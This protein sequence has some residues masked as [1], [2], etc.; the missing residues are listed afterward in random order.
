MLST[1][2]C[3]I[4][5]PTRLAFLD[6]SPPYLHFFHPISKFTCTF[7]PNSITTKFSNLIVYLGLLVYEICL[8]YPPYLFIW[9]YLFNW[10][11]RVHIS[12]LLQSHCKADDAFISTNSVNEALISQQSITR[13]FNR[14]RLLQQVTIVKREI[15]QLQYNLASST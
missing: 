11:L 9:P 7:P 8:K 14:D 13:L 2:R 4:N 6:F 3:Q 5:E 1:L 10:H 15:I 12:K